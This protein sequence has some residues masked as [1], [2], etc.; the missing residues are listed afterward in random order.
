MGKSTSVC[1]ECGRPKNLQL[2]VL[3]LSGNGRLMRGYFH[4]RCYKK[5]QREII[6]ATR[7][8]V[9][10]STIDDVPLGITG[11]RRVTAVGKA[12]Q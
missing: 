10:V 9:L 2:F 4:P 6:Y 1:R 11:T 5:V 12:L 8:W 7:R 3:A